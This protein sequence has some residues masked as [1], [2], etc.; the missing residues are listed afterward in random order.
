[1]LLRRYFLR[2]FLIGAFAAVFTEVEAGL[3]AGL[4]LFVIEV[5]LDR[6]L[7]DIICLFQ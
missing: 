2:P 1:L 4:L 3:P 7:K 5:V 6:S